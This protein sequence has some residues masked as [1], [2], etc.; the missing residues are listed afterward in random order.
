MLD[1]SKKERI[2]H[3][4]IKVLSTRFQSFP[5]DSSANRNAP[6]HEAFLQAF[7]NKLDEKMTDVP[8]LIS[9]SSWLH[10]LNTTLGQSFFEKVANILS[11]GEKRSF[12]KSNLL[13][14][15]AF[16]KVVIADIITD[17]KNRQARPDL[18]N[19]NYRLFNGEPSSMVKANQFDADVFIE[20]ADRVIA[21]ELKSVKPNAGELRGE[22]QKI[23]EG[24]AALFHAFP[25]KEIYFYIGFPFDPTSAR[26]EPMSSD[27]ERFLTNIVDGKKYFDFE[28]VL[29][30]EELWNFLSGEQDTMGEILDLINKIATPEFIV[31][32]ELIKEPKNFLR[33]QE[34]YLNILEEWSLLSDLNL[35]M[36]LSSSQVNQRILQND[37]QAQRL[38]NSYLFKD[39]DGSYNLNRRLAL[40][41]KLI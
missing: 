20:E 38:F 15:T 40:N 31:K 8:Y 37:R 11:G 25:G 17:L 35:L 24:K 29:L 6:F 19:E 16:Q 33:N 39:D 26:S 18:A 22:K 2:S 9:L 10:G 4:I 14:V 12:S 3:Q 5:S 7:H 21:I 30:A 23:L 32:Y 28:E 27:K 1:L 41:D 34:K 36:K 13:Q